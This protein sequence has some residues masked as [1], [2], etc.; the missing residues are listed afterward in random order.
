MPD[1]ARPEA[2][3]SGTGDDHRIADSAGRSASG[4]QTAETPMAATTRTAATAEAQ[5]AG[6]SLWRP[7]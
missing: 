6:G 2:A 4:R 1:L 5:A 7:L 3:G